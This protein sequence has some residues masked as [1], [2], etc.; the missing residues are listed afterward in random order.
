M[1]KSPQ[2]RITYAVIIGALAAFVYGNIDQSIITDAYITTG[3][4]IVEPGSYLQLTPIDAGGAGSR[5]LYN[6][7]L[8][9]LEGWQAN[10]RISVN[11]TMPN[12]GDGQVFILVLLSFSLP[13]QI[14]T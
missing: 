8:P 1:A 11:S 14:T 12:Y 10:Y 2:L 3:S 9:V 4:A 5:V 13:E 7:T 6:T